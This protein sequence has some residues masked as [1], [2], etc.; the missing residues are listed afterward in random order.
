MAKVESSIKIW[1]NGTLAKVESQRKFS[2]DGIVD[3]IL[4]K[5]TV[6]GSWRRSD[7]QRK[8][9]EGRIVNEMLAKV[10]P[11]TEVW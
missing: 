10:G 3:Q 9:G 1:R 11:L 2:E 7:Q 5:V 4:A 8:F 6:N